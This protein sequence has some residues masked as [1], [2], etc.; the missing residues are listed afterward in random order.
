LEYYYKDLVEVTTWSANIWTIETSFDRAN[1]STRYLAFSNKLLNESSEIYQSSKHIL[2]FSNTWHFSFQIF[3]FPL[4]K[5]AKM[6]GMNITSD[7]RFLIIRFFRRTKNTRYP[8]IIE[9]KYSRMLLC[10]HYW[11]Y[12]LKSRYIF[13]CDLGRLIKMPVHRYAITLVVIFQLY[14]KRQRIMNSIIVQKSDRTILIL[15]FSV[16]VNRWKTIVLFICTYDIFCVFHFVK[17]WII[18]NSLHNI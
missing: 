17:H 8:F 13:N 15:Y 5:L 11:Y 18:F 14:F 12:Y 3:I 9:K 6:S 16:T 7:R 4:D 1:L 10:S 2:C